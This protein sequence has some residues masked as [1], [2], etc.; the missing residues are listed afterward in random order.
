[1]ID[2]T[3]ID[4]ETANR[5]WNSICQIGL[6]VYKNGK[7]IHE[8]NQLIHPPGNYFWPKFTEI[9]G[10]DAN[11][12]QNAPTLDEIW[13]KI[14]PYFKNQNVVAHNGLRFDFPVLKATLEC[15]NIKVPKYTPICTYQIYKN[16]LAKIC[17]EHN[18]ALSNHDALSD[19]K[20]CGELYLR[21]LKKKNIA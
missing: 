2:F 15:Y 20:A 6:T 17:L 18:I 8:I 4:F 14:E 7:L 9:H 16:G 12:T 1:M 19:A 10:I 3:A 21:Y 11:Q 13:Y 5:D